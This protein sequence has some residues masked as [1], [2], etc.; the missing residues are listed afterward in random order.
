[1][2]KDHGKTAGPLRFWLP[3]GMAEHATAIGG[4]YLDLLRFSR[5]P[6]GWTGKEVTHNRLEMTVS[7]T[8]PWL[9][10][11]EPAR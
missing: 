9:K 6:E 2:H 11:S 3:V 8:A 5:M 10:G 7:E 1:M 4:I